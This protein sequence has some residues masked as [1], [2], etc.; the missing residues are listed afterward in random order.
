MS[1]LLRSCLA[2]TLLMTYFFTA[3]APSFAE[4][5][6]ELNA[7]ILQT[8]EALKTQPKNA[9]AYSARGYCYLGLKK[10]DEAEKDLL[11]AVSLDSKNKDNYLQLACLYSLRKQ[12]E[13]ALTN[14]RLAM[15]FGSQSMN[16]YDME[17]AYLSSSGRAKECLKRC[18]EVLR[19][20]PEDS[21]A[22]YFRAMSKQELG[23]GNDKEI[24][25]DLSTAVRLDPSAEG[26]KKDCEIFLSRMKAK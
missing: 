21:N 15:K 11:K 18:D 3:P 4:T 17:L 1:Y 14:V 23:I 16:T 20:F 5:E 12:Y 13:K 19:R 26:K 10:L 24:L 22:F 6:A 9:L 7:G 25:S 8:T 2:F